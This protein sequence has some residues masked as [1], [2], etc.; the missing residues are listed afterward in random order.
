MREVRSERGKAWR[1]WYTE[2]VQ[3]LGEHLHVCGDELDELA[4]LPVNGV[5]GLGHGDKKAKKC[6][7]LNG[8]VRRWYAAHSTQETARSSCA[9]CSAA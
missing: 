5:R 1:V 3:E 2:L 8:F 9:R 4:V 6:F 7:I